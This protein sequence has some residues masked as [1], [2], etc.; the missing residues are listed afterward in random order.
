[1]TNAKVMFNTESRRLVPDNLLAFAG[2]CMQGRW[3]N[4]EASVLSR[5]VR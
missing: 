1:M 3:C 4:K 2:A 5:I